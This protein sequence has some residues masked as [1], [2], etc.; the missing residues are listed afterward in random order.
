MKNIKHGFLRRAVRLCLAMMVLLT[1]TVIVMAVVTG[2]NIDAGALGVL[3]G[4]WCGE[5]LLSLLKR[6]FEVEDKQE[7][8]N[9]INKM[10]EDNKT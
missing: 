9:E 10:T 3:M 4:G 8:N 5:L 6:K 7:N 1:V 2:A